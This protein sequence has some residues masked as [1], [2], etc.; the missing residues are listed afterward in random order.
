MKPLL[1]LC[2][3]PALC[4]AQSAQDVLNRAEP[5]ITAERFAEAEQ[6][7]SAAVQQESGNVELLYR[8]GYVQYRQRKLAPAR[9]SFARAVKLSPAAWYSM[10]F[11]GQISLLENKPAEA[12]NWLRPIVERGEPVFDAAARLAAA[13]TQTGQVDKAQQNLKIAIAQAPWDGSLYFRLGQLQKKQGQP[14]LAAA[15]FAPGSSVT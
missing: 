1:I 14:E 7:L 15:S 4:L 3:V 6:I 8:L 13:Y 10:Y 11:L 12:I 2:A 9:E 5:L